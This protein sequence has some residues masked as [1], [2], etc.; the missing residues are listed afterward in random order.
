MILYDAC[1]FTRLSLYA[2][3][4]TF[5]G[6]DVRLDARM[7]AA[8]RGPLPAPTTMSTTGARGGPWPCNT[9]DAGRG[10]LCYGQRMVLEHKGMGG[11]LGPATHRMCG[12]RVLMDKGL[13]QRMI[14]AGNEGGPNLPNYAVLLLTKTVGFSW[15][16][17]D[18]LGC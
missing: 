2:V 14:F 1:H 15:E 13:W 9:Q 12:K 5:R 11:S 18:G 10:E 4:P 6:T 16:S 8:T 7:A 17:G 3:L